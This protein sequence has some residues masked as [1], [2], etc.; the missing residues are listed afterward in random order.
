MVIVGNN[1]FS[2]DRCL[3]FGRVQKGLLGNCWG[4]REERLSIGTIIHVKR[5]TAYVWA[6]GDPKTGLL[7]YAAPPIVGKRFIR[8]ETLTGRD[9]P[10][11]SAQRWAG[12]GSKWP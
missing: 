12:P 8:N 7:G 9:L 1:R 10:P 3:V 11:P 2:A 6:E 4:P 5:L